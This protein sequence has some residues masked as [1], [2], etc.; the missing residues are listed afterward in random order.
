MRVSLNLKWAEAAPSGKTRRQPPTKQNLLKAEL[1]ASQSTRKI[2]THVTEIS[3][4]RHE[5]V[6]NRR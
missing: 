6:T 5:G 4:D 3:P 1:L 2:P